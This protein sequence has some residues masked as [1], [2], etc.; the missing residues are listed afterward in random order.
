MAIQIWKAKIQ[1]CDFLLAM[2]LVRVKRL[3]ALC[4]RVFFYYDLHQLKYEYDMMWFWY[5]N[6]GMK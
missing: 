5:V 2:V 3:H 6:S 4:V 1:C